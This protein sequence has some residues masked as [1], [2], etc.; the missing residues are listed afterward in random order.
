MPE[1][2]DSVLINAPRGADPARTLENAIRGRRSVAVVTD[3]APTDEEMREMVRVAM[4]APDHGCLRPWRLVLVRGGERGALGAA[5]AASTASSADAAPRIAA[6]PLRAPLLV[7][8]V[9]RPRAHDRIPE[10]EQ[11]AASVAVVTTLML[12]LH[13]RGWASIW[14]TGDG[15]GAPAVR[16]VMG[17]RG[18][19]KLLGWL[20]VG[21]TD[22]DAPPRPARPAHPVSEHLTAL[23]GAGLGNHVPV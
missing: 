8:I 11:L 10:W 6:K 18:S 12:V 23:K 1:L 3:E 9:L 21:G 22:P 7:G 4:H 16:H 19:E 14:R 20:Y 15:L 5:L 13:D 2:V 17:I